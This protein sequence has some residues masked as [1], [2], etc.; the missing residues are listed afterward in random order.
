MGA[1]PGIMR[2]NGIDILLMMYKYIDISRINSNRI[3]SD[4]NMITKL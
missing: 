1:C 3:L 2:E 4:D